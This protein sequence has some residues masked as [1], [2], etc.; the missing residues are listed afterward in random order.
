[1]EV[2]PCEAGSGQMDEPEDTNLEVSNSHIDE[3]SAIGTHG[4]LIDTTRGDPHL[5]EPDSK[6]FD[7]AINSTNLNN[8]HVIKTT[9]QMPVE[10][11]QH[12]QTCG[13][14][15]ANVPDPPHIHT[16]V[17][18]PFVQQSDQICSGMD[19]ECKLAPAQTFVNGEITIPH[20]HEAQT[21]PSDQGVPADKP[22]PLE[23]WQEAAW[24]PPGRDRMQM[25]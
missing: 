12:I 16:V 25:V 22:K 18:N 6:T 20:P 21:T 11:N 3:T 1:M 9:S 24:L 4:Q 23:D 10:H 2:V 7:L 19:A 14:P 17:P 5:F 15:I 8:A 13:D